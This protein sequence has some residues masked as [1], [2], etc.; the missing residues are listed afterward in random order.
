MNINNLSNSIDE[1]SFNS[2]LNTVVRYRESPEFSSRI[3]SCIDGNDEMLFSQSKAAVKI[4]FNKVEGEINFKRASFGSFNICFYAS[5]PKIFQTNPFGDHI[6]LIKKYFDNNFGNF[7]WDLRTYT[8]PNN[9]WKVQN[10]YTIPEK[11]PLSTGIGSCA[12]RYS[13]IKTDTLYKLE[14]E[15]SQ[16]YYL[17]VSGRIYLSDSMYKSAYNFLGI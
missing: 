6:K 9:G 10:Y 1:S 16:G 2:I 13:L 15:L 5:L 7:K 11:W 4:M 17:P 3:L 8:Q 12:C 14:I